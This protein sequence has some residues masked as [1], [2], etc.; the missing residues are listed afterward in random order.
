LKWIDGLAIVVVD[1]PNDGVTPVRLVTGP[2]T[3]P[4]GDIFNYETMHTRLANEH[5]AAF[6]RI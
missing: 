3:P 6:T 1:M 5:D 2:P 4:P